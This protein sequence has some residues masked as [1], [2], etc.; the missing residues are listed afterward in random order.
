MTAP[1][2]AAAIMRDVPR[3]RLNGYDAATEPAKQG[4]I[5]FLS[6]VLA[7]LSAAIDGVDERA[8]EV[9]ERLRGRP[10]AIEDV[11]RLRDEAADLITAFLAQNAALRG[12]VEAME[13]LRPIWA[14]GWTDDSA[15]AQASGSALAQLWQMLGASNQTEAVTK[16]RALLAQNAALRAERDAL[17]E[18][19]GQASVRAESAED[20][21]EAAEAERDALRAER[22]DW[23]EAAA[24]A[25]QEE[26]IRTR[27]LADETTLREAA[28]AEVEKLRGAL[29]NCVGMLDC[30]VA[31]SG[32]SIEWDQEDPFRM[33][34][35]FEPDDLKQL[36]Q[37]R[38]ALS[39]TTEEGHE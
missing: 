27:Q 6:D 29:H 13:H 12:R 39:A 37:A 25:E 10:D 17:I 22:D 20:R 9:L 36:A 14:H 3:Y 1:N 11:D 28:E 26:R 7:A 21:A 19:N 16:L 8:G 18:C 15:A 34:E 2:L 31:E 23:Q 30:L 32:R 24:R 33:G 4:G 35:W 38:A 5:V